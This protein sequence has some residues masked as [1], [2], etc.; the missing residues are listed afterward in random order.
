MRLEPP[1]NSSLPGVESNCDA[2]DEPWP[3]REFARVRQ[4]GKSGYSRGSLLVSKSTRWRQARQGG[5]MTWGRD[6]SVGKKVASFLL[7]LDIHPRIDLTEKLL[8]SLDYLQGIGL[9]G[10]FFL[11]AVLISEYRLGPLLRRLVADGHQLGSHG[12]LHRPP[13][14]FMIDSLRRQREALARSKE[15]IEQEVQKQV[16]AFRAPTF[17]L[18]ATTMRALE[19]TGYQV[20]LS[21]TPQR[22]GLLSSQPGNLGWLAC[23]RSPYHPSYRTPFRPGTM[24]LWEIPTSSFVVP[25]TSLLYQSLGLRVAKGFAR[26]LLAEARW[27]RRPLV[28]LG[29]PE[30]FVS[31]TYVRPKI[32]MTLNA[33]VPR[34]SGGIALRNRLYERDEQKIFESS[35]SMM[36]FFCGL[37]AVR[38]LTVDQYLERLNS[39]T[40]RGEL[41]N[42][43]PSSD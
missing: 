40:D 11:P 36:G 4:G 38:Y 5:I 21:V 33:L 24:R 15:L 12:L 29:H 14:N 6:L 32:P 10:T 13:E 19:E 16:T 22:L 34:R 18:S 27:M 9:Q 8:A 35:V 37:D 28:Y 41:T 30:E 31:S 43:V 25:F 23:P 26:G 2:I 17:M 39:S 1:V 42:P 3:H 20:D 7:T